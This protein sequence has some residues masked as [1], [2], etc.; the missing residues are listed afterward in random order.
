LGLELS[1][2]QINVNHKI[3]VL[4]AYNP[5]NFCSTTY[6]GGNSWHFLLWLPAKLSNCNFVCTKTE[7]SLRAVGNA[8]RAGS[9]R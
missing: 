7:I 3:N 2:V 5:K 1:K 8:R 9:L 4:K 6:K